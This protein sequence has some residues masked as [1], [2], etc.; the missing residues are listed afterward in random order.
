MTCLTSLELSLLIYFLASSSPGSVLLEVNE[1]FAN[2]VKCHDFRSESIKK[3]N[4]LMS[5]DGKIEHGRLTFYFS[6]IKNIGN[7]N[8][9]RA[10][11]T[12][13]TEEKLKVMQTS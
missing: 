2:A 4:V 11:Y 6:V 7:S 3:V 10:F 8:R 9:H 1:C 13:S 5:E 12:E